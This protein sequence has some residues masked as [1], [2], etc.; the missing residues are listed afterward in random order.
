M[1]RLVVIGIGKLRFVIARSHLFFVGLL[2]VALVA[3]S[4]LGA[5]AALNNSTPQPK[6]KERVIVAPP[7]VPA[8]ATPKTPTPK[9]NPKL[10]AALVTFRVGSLETTVKA[11]IANQITEPKKP[12]SPKKGYTFSGWSY[13][14]SGTTSYWD[15][16]TDRIE[17]PELVLTAAFDK[18]LKKDPPKQ[19]KKPQKKAPVS[20]KKKHVLVIEE[21]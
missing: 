18:P 14:T 10:T 5:Y 7:S 20:K 4:G 9:P 13:E 15:F 3:G 8:T 1:S 19:S 6:Q 17:T 21:E 2:A 16:K 12:K 11:A